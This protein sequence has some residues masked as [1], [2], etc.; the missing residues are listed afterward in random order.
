[1]PVSSVFSSLA[2]IKYSISDFSSPVA[3]MEASSDINF[4]V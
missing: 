1:M 3:F 2:F 4:H